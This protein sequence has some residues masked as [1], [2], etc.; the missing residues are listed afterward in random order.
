MQKAARVRHARLQRH[1]R[2]RKKVSGTSERP[3][4]NVFRSLR[5][6]Y[7][8]IIDDSVG[9]TLASASTR[10]HEVQA[11]C[12]GLE[13]SEA[14]KIVGRVIA[15]RALASGVTRVVLDRGG[16][17]YHGRVQ[18]LAEAAREAGLDF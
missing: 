11:Q 7:A 1:R 13:K 3:R 18:A 10:D 2:V 16:Y 4:L 8:Q 5:H 17:R 12:T 6:M 9:H 15:Q 14:A